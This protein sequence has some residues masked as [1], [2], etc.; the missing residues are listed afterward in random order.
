MVHSKFFQFHRM[1]ILNNRRVSN[2]FVTN[3]VI[4]NFDFSKAERI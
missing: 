1:T 2:N 4:T 3:T